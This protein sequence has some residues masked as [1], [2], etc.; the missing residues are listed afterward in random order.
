VSGSG[1][2]T[3]TTWTNG[4]GD[5]LSASGL[6]GR[7]TVGTTAAQPSIIIGGS[8]A[9]SI[10]TGAF[11]TTGTVIRGGGGDDTISTALGTTAS[12]AAIFGDDGADVITGTLTKDTI[13]GGAGADKMVMATVTNATFSNAAANVDYFTDFTAG[14]DKI[15]LAAGNTTA[16]SVLRNATTT[17][18]AN[19]AL[20]DATADVFAA[21]ANVATNMGA[22][23][24]SSYTAANNDVL[25]FNYKG[26][27]YAYLNADTTTTVA[28]TDYVVKLTGVTG[29]LAASDF[30]IA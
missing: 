9:D 4:A 7:L 17:S 23:S 1:N 30:L 3:L 16:A 8:G 19:Q 18:A 15:V 29:T 24:G 6:T 10:T 11:A 21:A 28:T 12:G 14:T 27:V 13:T 26:D 22:Y 20:I 2:L 25:V 5:V